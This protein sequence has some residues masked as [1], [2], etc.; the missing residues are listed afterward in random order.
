M[1]ENKRYGEGIE[2]QIEEA[3][4]RPQPIGLTDAELDLA[5]HPITEAQTPIPVRAYLRFPEAVIR[6]ECVVIAWTDRA[7]KLRV[8]MRNSTATDVWVWASAV[9]RLNGR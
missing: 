5:H 8:T 9:E 6:P 1:G 7:V 2:Q 4:I 3:V